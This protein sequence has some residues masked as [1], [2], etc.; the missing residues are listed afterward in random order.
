MTD[1]TTLAD[2]QAN[3]AAAHTA[4][5]A[6]LAAKSTGF[7]DRSLVRHDIDKLRAEIEHWSRLIV[8]LDPDQARAAR[9]I[10]NG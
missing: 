9:L 2:A 7:G 1:T 8:R 10:V 4:Y 6:A 3:L 5:R